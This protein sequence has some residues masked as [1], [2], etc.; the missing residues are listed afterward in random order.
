MIRNQTTPKGRKLAVAALLALSITGSL[1]PASAERRRKQQQAEPVAAPSL[2][3]APVMAIASLAEQR[4][5]LYDAYGN[6]I[7]SKIS[8]GQTGYETPVGIY[9]V[10]QKNREHYSNVYDGASMHFM[11]RITWSGV[12]LHE[13]ALPGYPASHG[14][15]RLPTRYASQIFPLT[16]IGMR[17]IVARDDTSPVP[18]SH[19]VLLQPRPIAAGAV[20]TKASYEVPNVSYQDLAVF[21]PDVSRWPARRAELDV[22]KADAQSKTAAAEALRP[23]AEQLKRSL[24]AKIAARNKTAKP[25]VKAESFKKSADADLARIEKKL[26]KASKPSI[27]AALEKDKTRALM[28]FAKANT[29]LEEERAKIKPIDD[30]VEAAKAAYAA[31]AAELAEAEAAALDAQRKTFPVSIFVSR[32]SQRIYVRQGHE[33]VLDLPVTIADPD[34]PIGTHVFTAIGYSDSGND[35]KWTAVTMTRR[36]T[37]ATAAYT[38][39]RSRR[40]VSL[41]PVPTDASSASAALDRITMPPEVVERFKTSA[42]VGSSLIVSDEEAHKETGKATDFIVLMSGEPQGGIVKRPKPKPTNKYYYYYGPGYGYGYSTSY[43]YSGKPG[44][45][46][47]ARPA[48]PPNRMKPAKKPALFSFW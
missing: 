22:L 35:L 30:A 20:L 1:D 11:Q 4:I 46:G 10:L 5:S 44:A 38:D 48:P 15:V 23:S 27:I 37:M 13:G 3:G 40:D 33:A 14:C 31:A 6:S 8:S 24:D 39:K 28:A 9:S 36:S 32:K 47:Y 7:R 12:A 42:W 41:D 45:Y 29:R 17:V 2:Q 18:I 43:Y 34:R 19:P 25:F 21:E 16:R 26:A